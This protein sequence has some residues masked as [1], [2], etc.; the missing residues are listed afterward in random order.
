MRSSHV[1]NTNPSGSCVPNMGLREE[2]LFLK[3]ARKP[4]EAVSGRATYTTATA[5]LYAGLAAGVRVGLRG[6]E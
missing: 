5:I 3:E 6:Y 4:P 2:K 1:P